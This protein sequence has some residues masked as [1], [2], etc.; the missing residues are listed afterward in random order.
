MPLLECT[1]VS[2][3]E[4]F[5]KINTILTETLLANFMCKISYSIMKKR[6]WICVKHNKQPTVTLYL[7]YYA[8]SRHTQKL[9]NLG[10]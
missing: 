7:L 1:I 9:A 10:S 8:V 3:N 5:C 4:V 6:I 2:V